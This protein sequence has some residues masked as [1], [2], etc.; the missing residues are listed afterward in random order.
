MKLTTHKHLLFDSQIGRKKPE[1]IIKKEN[2]C[3]FCDRNNLEDIIDQEDSMI[4]LK[5][6]FPVLK[7]TLQTVLVETDQCQSDLSN[8]PKEHLYRLLRFGIKNWF[9]MIDSREF[10][11]VSFFRNYGP[12]SGGSIA[13][14][15]S[16]IVAFHNYDYLEKINKQDFVGLIIDQSNSVELNISTQ[17]RVGFYEFNVILKDVDAIPR[18]ADYIQMVA[19]YILNRFIFRCSSYNVFYY[20]FED[21]I[22][23]KIV[24]RF[25]TSPL[26]IGYSIPQVPN[27]L[28][29]VL[30]DFT[31]KYM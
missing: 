20:N 16:Q 21:S 25:V 1:T 14:P 7:E 11:S 30:E 18:F 22:I 12:L 8:Y 4:L 27:N 13:H 5:N 24:P 29:D 17:P 19:H 10:T 31:K 6:K 26:Y 9:E 28:E 3:P 15:H 2:S 23:A